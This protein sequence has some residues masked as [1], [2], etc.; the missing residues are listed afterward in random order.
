MSNLSDVFAG[1]E[2]VLKNNITSI[3]VYDHEPDNFNDWPAV[4][5]ETQGFDPVI[6]FQGNSFEAVIRLVV[7]YGKGEATEAYR[8][9]Y[10]GLDPTETNKSVIRALRADPT[11][12][13]TV[14]DSE[15]GEPEDFGRKQMSAGWFVGFDLPLSVIKTVA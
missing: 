2:A 12:N 5:M 6:A 13:S 7:L 15:V 3:V 10:D 1:I 8:D 9:M 4:V 14:D 11:L